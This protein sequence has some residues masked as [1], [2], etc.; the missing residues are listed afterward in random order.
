MQIIFTDGLGNQMFQFA[1]YLAMKA[2]GRHPK[3]NTG[4]IKRNIVHN[5]FELCDVFMIEENQLP[6]AMTSSFAG[7]MTI[8]A[9]RYVDFL[10][11]HQDVEHYSDEVFKT[12]KIFISGYWQD[13]KYFKQVQ[14]KVKEVFVFRNI[15]D[16]NL[17]LGGEMSDCNSVSLH[18]R[19]GDYLKYPNYQVCTSTYYEQAVEKIHHQVGNP[20]F[21]VFSDDLE[22]S[23]NFMKKLGVN[24]KLVSHNRGKDSYRDMFLMT[25]CRH[26]II[27]NSSFSW[28]GAW[29]GKNE[30]KMIVCPNTWVKGTTLD[31]C[32][33]EWI[34]INN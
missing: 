25:C 21:Y 10:C 17:Q 34:R 13:V 27:A 29:L 20:L 11:Y 32:P 31:P 1:L 19:R 15:D 28:W 2:K 22:W 5:G 24:Y 3:I 4:S 30:E 12:K 33:H 23:E 14:E 7:S 6:L 9:N 8:I 16:F 26:H 18:I